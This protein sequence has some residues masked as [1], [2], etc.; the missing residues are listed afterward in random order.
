MWQTLSCLDWSPRPPSKSQNVLSNGVMGEVVV[1][2]I[3]T[4][5]NVEC[6]VI[7]SVFPNKIETNDRVAKQTRLKMK[8]HCN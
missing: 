1:I 6:L 2:G 8:F 4:N 5:F 3:K 7:F